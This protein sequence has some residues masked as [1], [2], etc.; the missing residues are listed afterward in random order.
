MIDGNSKKLS[1]NHSLNDFVQWEGWKYKLKVVVIESELHWFVRSWEFAALRLK[2]DS[3]VSVHL[4]AL[5]VISW[6]LRKSYICNQDI[7]LSINI[8]V[9][10]EKSIFKESR[11]D[12]VVYYQVYH[13]LEKLVDQ[14]LNRHLQEIGEPSNNVDDKIPWKLNI[15]LSKVEICIE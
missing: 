3:T 1:R 13:W 6:S 5:V 12:E 9:N 7:R 11:D 4:H 14:N 8:G 2:V 15:W 10:F